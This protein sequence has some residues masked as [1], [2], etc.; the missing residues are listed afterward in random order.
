MVRLT[1]LDVASCRDAYSAHDSDAARLRAMLLAVKQPA[2]D[3]LVLQLCS[4]VAMARPLAAAQEGDAKSR[5]EP[6]TG[7]ASFDTL[8]RVV[9]LQV[10]SGED[11]E[12]DTVLAF[13]ALGGKADKTGSVA[14]ERLRTVCK[15]RGRAHALRGRGAGGAAVRRRGLRF[16]ISRPSRYFL[17]F[18]SSLSPF[19]SLRALHSHMCRSSGS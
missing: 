2:A 3:D 8:L 11:G 4:R 10:K 16:C 12:E 14:T 19:L 5:D 6:L 9:E 7:A 15:A 17:S 18:L 13:A 1:Q